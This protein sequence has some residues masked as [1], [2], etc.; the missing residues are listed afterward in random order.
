MAKTEITGLKGQF[1]LQVKCKM[2]PNFSWL[3]D[4]NLAG[5][6]HIG[7]WGVYEKEILNDDLNQLLNEGIRA[8]VSLTE[9]PLD[10]VSVISKGM[11][12]LHIP[13]PD[14]TPPSLDA[15]NEFVRFVDGQFGEKRP[16]LVHCEAGLGRTGTMLGCYLVKI[17]LS[18]GDAI[19]KVR[20][21]RPGSIET[22]AQ[23]TTV[24]EYA[25]YAH[26]DE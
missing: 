20:S 9:H 8:I 18:P 23:E 7:G 4:G 24:F 26:G 6:G 17:G 25:D 16:V 15:V 5:S 11:N 22:L 13:I 19:N 21:H 10:T 3:I 12:Y 2:I 1:Q 14:M